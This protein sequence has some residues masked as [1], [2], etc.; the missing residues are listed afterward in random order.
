M[1][2]VLFATDYD[3]PKANN[4]ANWLV[5]NF[6]L[7]LIRSMS[8]GPFVLIRNNIIYEGYFN[9]VLDVTTIHYAE[10]KDKKDQMILL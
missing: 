4:I 5:H 2:R 6:N 3:T 7:K 10:W 8:M 1:E 9:L